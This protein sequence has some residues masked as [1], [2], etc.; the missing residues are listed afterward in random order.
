[1]NMEDIK[2]QETKS[3][4]EQ[5]LPASHIEKMDLTLLEKLTTIEAAEKVGENVYITII[6]KNP[7]LLREFNDLT[8]QN[9]KV[10]FAKMYSRYVNNSEQMKNDIPEIYQFMKERVFYGRL[11]FTG[12]LGVDNMQHI[13][14]S[15][16]I[17]SAKQKELEA[18]SKLAQAHRAEM[19]GNHNKASSLKAQ[20]SSLKS[21]ARN[22]RK[23][24]E[25]LLKK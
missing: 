11:N 9:G 7:G 18:E 13:R 22:D 17:N 21:K 10:G 19:N 4:F 1:M 3:H 20:A 15:G 2:I 12:G 23:E 8:Q 5:E 25:K 24:G 14:G 6:E 16:L